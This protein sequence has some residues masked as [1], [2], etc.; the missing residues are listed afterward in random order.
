M[1]TTR[2]IS[3]N[4]FNGKACI[5]INIICS[6]ISPCTHPTIIIN[7][8]TSMVSCKLDNILLIVGLLV[9]FDM[10]LFRNHGGMYLIFPSLITEL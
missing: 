7:L 5:W 3:M 8:R 1:A 4:N 10:N 6:R 2:G 9:I